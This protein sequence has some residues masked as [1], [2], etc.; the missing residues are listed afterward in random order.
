VRRR[1]FPKAS[2]CRCLSWGTVR[3]CLENMRASEV[4]SDDADQMAFSGRASEVVIHYC[5]VTSAL[6]FVMKMCWCLKLGSM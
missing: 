2:C 6:R 4:S 5:M 3:K 1:R